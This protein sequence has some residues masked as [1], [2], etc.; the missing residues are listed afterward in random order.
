MVSLRQTACQC[1]TTFSESFTDY[2]PPG[3]SIG[4]PPTLPLAII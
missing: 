1:F 3:A 2:P 4:Y